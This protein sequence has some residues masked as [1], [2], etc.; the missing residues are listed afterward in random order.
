M[1]ASESLNWG[2]KNEEGECKPLQKDQKTKDY[3]D[4]AKGRAIALSPDGDELI[5]GCKNGVVRIYNFN[6]H[7]N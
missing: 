5:V 6:E 4:A 1:L 7:T 3:S 2:P